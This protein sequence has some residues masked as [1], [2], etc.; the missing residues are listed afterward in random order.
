MQQILDLHIHSRYSRACSPDLV[1]SKIDETCR[2]K[3]I[4]IIATGDYTFPDYL[5]SIK[6]ELEEI[7]GA[8]GLYKLKAVDNTQV[9]FILSTE[10]ALIYKKG[11]KVRRVH[12]CVMAPNIESA[13]ELFKALDADFNVRSDGRPILGMTIED[14]FH[15]ALKINPD[16][17]I[18]PAHIWTPWFSIFGSKSGFDSLDEA[19]GD[20]LEYVYAY[21][22]GLSSDA[23][24][25]WRVSELDKL[26]MLSNSDAHSLKNLAREANIWEMDKISFLEILRVM[27]ER[28]TSVIKQTIEFFPEEGMYHYDGHRACQ[29]MMTP[30]ETRRHKGICPKC[31]KPMVV[32]VDY[33]VDELADREV[34]FQLAGA[35]AYV[36]LVELD[37]I[38]A[39]ALGIKSRTSKKV[40]AEYQR[41]IQIYGP[42]LNILLDVK[43]EDLKVSALPR[44]AEGIKRVRAGN[45]HIKPGFD[46][47]YG[48]VQIFSDEEKLQKKLL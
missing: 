1:L 5:A 15:I 24:M 22:T 2:T 23:E 10:L 47:Q 48:V 43:V 46:G 38:I 17:I 42:E 28:D 7:K 11:A 6:E 35:P 44:V 36:K 12:I 39:A 20:Q 33:R 8:E 21:E 25:N 40:L 19:F 41:M 13:T 29:V 9:K 37:K 30:A 16:F 31:K 32:G 27:K 45:L 14:L 34:G 26:T 4:N 3:G 18:F